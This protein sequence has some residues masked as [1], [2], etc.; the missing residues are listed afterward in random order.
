VLWHEHQREF[1]ATQHGIDWIIGVRRI[2]QEEAVQAC[3]K[4]FTPLYSLLVDEEMKPSQSR[5]RRQLMALAS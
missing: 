3:C 4:A 5:K 1:L 2:D